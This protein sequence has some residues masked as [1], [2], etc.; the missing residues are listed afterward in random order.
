MQALFEQVIARLRAGGLRQVYPSFDA[1]PVRKK[2][3][4]LFAVVEPRQVQMD[5]P[6]ADG[7]HGAVPFTAIY[8]VHLLIPMT[9]PIETAED[10]FYGTVLPSLAP[11]G[12]VLCEVVPAHADVKLSRVVM[13]AR[14]RQ[15]GVYLR[16][17]ADG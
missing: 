13:E 16:E 14:F 15:R 2:S 1:V 9:Q 8:S 12:C 10:V 7:S 11:M 6:F 3:D 17:E 4:T 5:A